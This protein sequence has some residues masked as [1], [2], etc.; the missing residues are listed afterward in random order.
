MFPKPF[1][2]HREAVEVI[3]IYNL[4]Y[5]GANYSC[6]VIFFAAVFL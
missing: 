3:N 6:K 2:E 4:Y 1:W 5:F